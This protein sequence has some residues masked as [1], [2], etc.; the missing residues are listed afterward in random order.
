MINNRYG[1]T[2][3]ADEKELLKTF[4]DTYMLP[5]VKQPNPD[6]RDG[7]F[8]EI[9]VNPG[10]DQNC[11]YCY[12]ARYGKELYPLDT[13][14][15]KEG[16]LHNLN[17][18]FDYFFEKKILIRCW[19][20]FGGDLF[21]DGIFWD[22]MD[23]FYERYSYIKKNYPYVFEEPNDS[24]YIE[25]ILPN[26]LSYFYD[27]E[28]QQKFIEY[29]DKLLEAHVMIGVSWSTDGKYA[30]N[31]REKRILP[32]DYWDKMFKFVYKIKAGIHPMVAPEN[33]KNWIENYDWFLDCFDKYGFHD[34]PSR[35]QVSMLEVRNGEWTD[36][37]LKD[38]FNL[39]KH[40]FY[41]RLEM[42]DNNLYKMARHL[43]IGDGKEGSLPKADQMDLI[44]IPV[45]SK[46]GPAERMTCSIQEQFH[47][48]LSD[49]AIVPCH[50]TSYPFMR[51]GYF[52][53]ENNK[54]IDIKPHNVALFIE[55]V[56][57][58]INMFPKCFTC[59][60]KDVCIRGCLGA[61][62]ETSGELFMPNENV[63]KMLGG[64]YDLLV[65]LVNESGVLQCAIDHNLFGTP[66][67]KEYWIN[68]SKEMGY[69]IYE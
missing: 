63:C 14:Q 25:V 34:Q 52:E 61:Q 36:E 40:I 47:V 9:I 21:K 68:R 46:T 8:V 56:S 30:V 69:T 62:Y 45:G 65:Q 60:H 37:N 35:F 66:E 28:Y 44:S 59:K 12:I 18:L 55:I 24:R 3:E 67:I 38:Y 10:C 7:E 6:W 57:S 2:Y 26:N 27:D 16:Q 31:T 58:P 39:I 33:V 11:S 13:R 53:V 17:L 20:I 15:D 22:I 23:I 49:L 54:I 48:I 29:K 51:A 5:G 50:R 32:D 4:I 41:K 43:F 64:K 42:N 19:E 1:K